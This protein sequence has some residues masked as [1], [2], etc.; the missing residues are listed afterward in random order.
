[1]VI[2]NIHLLIQQLIERNILINLS[3]LYTFINWYILNWFKLL[4]K[5][6]I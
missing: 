6:L 2:M 5:Y 3:Y 1:M 4:K